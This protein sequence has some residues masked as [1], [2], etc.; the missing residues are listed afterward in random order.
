[1]FEFQRLCQISPSRSTDL[2]DKSFFSVR[3][4]AVAN[5]WKI[6]APQNEFVIH[7]NLIR[8]SDEQAKTVDDFCV[9][10]KFENDK[11]P[12]TRQI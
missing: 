8:I 7:M 1:M 9:G 10:F 5:L 11:H 4:K 2:K 12:R 3:W 6:Y